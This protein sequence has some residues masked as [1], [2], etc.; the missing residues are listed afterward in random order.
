MI[1]IVGECYY[2]EFINLKLRLFGATLCY[3]WEFINLK[4]CLFR[5]KSVVCEW[6][7]CNLC[8]YALYVCVFC[9]LCCMELLCLSTLLQVAIFWA[10]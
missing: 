3:Y 9:S 8:L 1:V 5:A 2:W 7:L 10:F 4:L 6:K